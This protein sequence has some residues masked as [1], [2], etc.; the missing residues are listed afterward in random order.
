MELL[1]C[2]L[3]KVVEQT[4]T[5]L[6]DYADLAQVFIA[7]INLV[8]VFVFFYKQANDSKTESK[9]N[10]RL[11]WFKELVMQP[12]IPI[13]NQFF[14]DVENLGPILSA[15]SQGEDGIM[16]VSRLLRNYFSKFKLKF[17]QPLLNIDSVL[18]TSIRSIIE[19]LE[20][21]ISTALLDETL[22]LAN[23]TLYDEQVT[24]KL[25]K[26]KTD[27]LTHIVNFGG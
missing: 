24:M 2:H 15:N 5:T 10:V 1:C 13:F 25:L 23:P 3:P 21:Q 19:D 8:F 14:I 22:D 7:I 11:Q 6:S 16:E 26:T 12:N 20:S 9:K 27:I 17:H 4:S 18:Y